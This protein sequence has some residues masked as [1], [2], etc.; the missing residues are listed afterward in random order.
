MSTLSR[1]IA[2]VKAQMGIWDAELHALE[3][4][5]SEFGV[6]AQERARADLGVVRAEWDAF[7]AKAAALETRLESTLDDDWDQAKADWH[8]AVKALKHDWKRLVASIEHVKDS[9]EK[10]AA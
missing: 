8:D 10:E 2:D 6:R 9:I 5:I 7:V 3:L 1:F 4:R